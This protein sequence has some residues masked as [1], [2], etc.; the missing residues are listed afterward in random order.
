M[1]MATWQR[2]GRRTERDPLGESASGEPLFGDE[3]RDGYFMVAHWLRRGVR[4]GLFSNYILSLCS[5]KQRSLGERAAAIVRR[6][7]LA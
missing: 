7:P 6:A 2:G 4:F 3:L 1:D 5:G